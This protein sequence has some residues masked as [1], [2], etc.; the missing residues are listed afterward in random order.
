MAVMHCV[1]ILALSRSTDSELRVFACV[2]VHVC[3]YDS[4]NL[5][6]P[7]HNCRQEC[8]FPPP[9]LIGCFFITLS[10]ISS[11]SASTCPPVTSAN[12]SLSFFF[13][14]FLA[15]LSG[16]P[17]PLFRLRGTDCQQ[18]GSSLE[19]KLSFVKW[20]INK[21][22]LDAAGNFFCLFHFIIAN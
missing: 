11:S 10:L 2:R 21:D 18:M 13:F 19:I 15:Y 20:I 6:C 7:F 1:S 4:T 12:A 9:S 8:L 3:V 22:L 16:P 5:L 14:F 17:G